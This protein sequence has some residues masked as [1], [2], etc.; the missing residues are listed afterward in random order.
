MTGCTTRTTRR[1][2]RDA[3]YDALRRRNAAIEAR[4]PD[5]V[6]ADSPSQPRRR[7]AG[8]RLRQGA[9][10]ACRCCRWT[11][12]STTR[13]S[14]SS[15]AR[16]R[17]FLGLATEAPLAFVAEPKI[18]G[19]S[20]NLTYEHGRFVHGATRG[21]GIEGEDVTA[22]LRTIGSVPDTAARPCAG[23]DR[24]P[25]RSVHDQGGFPGAERGAGQGGA[26]AIR[27]S[28]QRRRRQPAPARSGDHRQPAAVAVRLCAG[29]GERGGGRHPLALP[30]AAARVGLPGQSAVASSAG[31]G[32]GGR[33]PAR[34]RPCNARRSATTSTAWSTR[35]T[36][37][38]LQRRLGFVGRAPRWAIA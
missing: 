27:Q 25:R 2:S 18:D 26:E 35:S 34:H 6:R 9:P 17:R 16:A 11:T 22:N 3:D 30:A 29:R 4:F 28:A 5:L 20:I 19:L 10:P 31:C 12:P 8:D 21:D 32:S 24:G 14:P 1:R 33:V 7:R 37:W 15:C 23:A 38:R 36:T 13:N